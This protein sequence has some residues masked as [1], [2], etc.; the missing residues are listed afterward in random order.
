MEVQL[1]L[2]TQNIHLQGLKGATYF[3]VCRQ[4]SRFHANCGQQKFPS[5]QLGSGLP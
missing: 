4:V 1:K 3:R 5:N 2:E